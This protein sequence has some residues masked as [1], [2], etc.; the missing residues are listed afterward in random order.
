[1]RTSTD[2]CVGQAE[3][4]AGCPEST[5]RACT[6]DAR[7]GLNTVGHCEA[8]TAKLRVYTGNG[9]CCL[10]SKDPNSSLSV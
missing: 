8:L 1:M 2:V 7:M 9:L 3:R 10:F 5:G 6:Y 4:K